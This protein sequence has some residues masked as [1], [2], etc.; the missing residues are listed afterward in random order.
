METNL[1][2]AWRVT[3]A[4]L[5]LLRRSRHPRIVNVSSESGS[6]SEMTGGTPAY[7][8]TKAA[9]NALTRPATGSTQCQACAAMTA[10]N[11]RPTGSQSSNFA[12]SVSVPGRVA[13]GE[14]Q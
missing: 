10:S 3:E 4:F 9:L 14:C 2:G 5:P 6:I 13:S 7:S 8:V 1:F 12:T 11:V